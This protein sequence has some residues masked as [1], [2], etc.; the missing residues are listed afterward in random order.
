MSVVAWDGKTLAA[1]RQAGCAGLRIETRK[2][3]RQEDG[4]VLAFTGS[5]DSMMMLL[6]WY[7]EG[8]KVEQWP[9]SQARKD[10]TRL[11]V[12]KPN[13]TINVYERYPEPEIVIYAPTA[14]GAGRDY[15]IGAMAMGADARKAVEVT[16]QFSESCGFGVDAFDVRPESRAVSALA[17]LRA[18]IQSIL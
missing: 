4:T 1:D 17:H 16:N 11:I 13:L 5:I 15:A 18:S 8:A 14:W 2:I 9:A 12:V 6:R 3:W 7:R 10:W